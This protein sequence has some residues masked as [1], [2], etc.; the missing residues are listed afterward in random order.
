MNYSILVVIG[1]AA[2]LIVALAA[3]RLGVEY[4]CYVQSLLMERLFRELLRRDRLLGAKE[5]RAS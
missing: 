5:E 1:L 4:G 3:F 2:G